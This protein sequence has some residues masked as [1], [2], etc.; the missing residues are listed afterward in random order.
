MQFAARF[1]VKFGV[2][3]AA[4]AAACAAAPAGD[5]TGKAIARG[6]RV[7]DV[8]LTGLSVQPARERV[9]HELARPLVVRVGS[10]TVRYPAGRFRVVADV[11]D[12]VRGALA[13][14][15]GAAIGLR[16]RFNRGAIDRAIGRLAR[17]FDR[18]ARDATVLDLD[19]SLRPVLGPS[20]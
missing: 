14:E 18:P 7:G 13:A 3:L 5:G 17:R 4:A 12:A 2:L 9:R 6:V 15:P 10:Q 20:A 8:V 11:D 16:T 1:G 19:A